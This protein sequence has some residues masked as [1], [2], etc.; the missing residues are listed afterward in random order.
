MNGLDREETDRALAR[1]Q[2]CFDDAFGEPARGFVAPA[3]QRG[4]VTLDGGADAGLEYVLG[5]F[6]VESRT[7][8]RIPLATWTWDCGR[9][10]WL[11]HV[12]HGLGRMLHSFD[13]RVPT[14]AIHPADLDRG[15]WPA[16]L[17]LVEGLLAR[18]YEP[19]TP[20]AL[21]EVHRDV[22]A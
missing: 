22:A 19:T 12:G 18:G 15:F 10:G 13:G 20:T 16:I 21:L 2:R 1:G 8:G 17:R 9:W 6:S 14:L 3:W 11:G 4:R 5:F 7:R